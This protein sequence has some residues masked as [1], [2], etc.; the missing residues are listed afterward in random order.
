MRKKYPKSN[1]SIIGRIM[2]DDVE[3]YTDSNGVQR[4]RLVSKPLEEIEYNIPKPSE[5]TLDNLLKAGVPLEVIKSTPLT[6]KSALERQAIDKSMAII[7]DILNKENSSPVVDV[8]EG[9]STVN[10]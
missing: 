4:R 2:V 6:K 7:S 10:T 8:K 9:D 5:Y 1:Q 3:V